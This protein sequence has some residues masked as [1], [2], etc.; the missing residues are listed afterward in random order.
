[1]HSAYL[2]VVVL[3]SAANFYAGV[4]DFTRPQ[5]LIT[6]I[7]RLGME[8]RWL[9]TLGV[10]KIIGGLG[11]LAGIALP[12]IGVAAAAGLVVYFIGAMVTV[13]RARWY[14]NLPFPLTWLALAIGS[15]VLRLLVA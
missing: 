7:E 14:V 11:L 2:T 1:M 15:F 13:L 10:L 12:Q 9:P 5:W 6:N 4:S 8:E 3:A